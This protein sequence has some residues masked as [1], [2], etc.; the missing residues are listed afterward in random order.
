MYSIILT[1]FLIFWLTATFSSHVGSFDQNQLHRLRKQ[2]NTLI[3]LTMI[4]IVVKKKEYKDSLNLS[5]RIF[6]SFSWWPDSSMDS[7]VYFYKL[8]IFFTICAIHFITFQAELWSRKYLCKD[9]SVNQISLCKTSPFIPLGDTSVSFWPHSLR[10]PI[11]TSTE[12]SVGVSISKVKIS[13]AKTSWA[14]KKFDKHQL[15]GFVQLS[16]WCLHITPETFANFCI[17][18]LDVLHQTQD[19]CTFSW[20]DAVSIVVGG[21]WGKDFPQMANFLYI[22]NLFH[23][24]ITFFNDLYAQHYNKSNLLVSFKIEALPNCADHFASHHSSPRRYQNI[25]HSI[26]W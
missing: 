9:S 18:L 20:S 14:W 6:L 11:A 24:K 23:L 1:L 10:N 17:Y 21:N 8:N 7:N 13:R 16:D 25:G 12:S 5:S 22:F 3:T 4:K 19:Y 26:G 15:T 2:V